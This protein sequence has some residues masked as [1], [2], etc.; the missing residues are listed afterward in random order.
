MKIIIFEYERNVNKNFY[1][2]LKKLMSYFLKKL[3]SKLIYHAFFFFFFIDILF[4]V[5]CWLNFSSLKYRSE[6]P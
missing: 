3:Y 1:F 2:V 6:T 5:Q 4:I